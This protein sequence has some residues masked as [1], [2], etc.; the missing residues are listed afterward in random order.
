ML[1]P[2]LAGWAL[3]HFSKQTA[4]AIAIPIL[5]FSIFSTTAVILLS[6]WQKTGSYYMISTAFGVFW[7]II[8]FK[9]H[10]SENKLLKNFRWMFF[11][12]GIL[13]LGVTL[14]QYVDIAF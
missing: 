10:Q 1:L 13:W 6:R 14:A 5:F 4:Y 12:F 2:I 11:I 9:N 8:S 7:I 3:G